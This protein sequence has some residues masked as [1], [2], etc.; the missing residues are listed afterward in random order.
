MTEDSGK[1]P[2]AMWWR[3]KRILLSMVS[4]TN[5]GQT[6]KVGIG[7]DVTMLGVNGMKIYDNVFGAFLT[8]PSNILAE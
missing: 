3:Q 4:L 6:T 1:L 8:I 2:L 7:L 5:N